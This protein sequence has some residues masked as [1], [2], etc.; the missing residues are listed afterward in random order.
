MPGSA[1]LSPALR[2]IDQLGDRVFLG[3]VL[4]SVVWSALAFVVLAAGV[5]Y[6]GHAILSDQGWLGWLAGAAG[7]LG[8][9]ILSLWLFLPLA[10]VI[11]SLFVERIAAAVER[12]YYPT[13]AQ[14]RP[15]SLVAQAQDGIV[16]GLRVLAMQAIA[17]IATL[18]PPHV[19]GL[20]VGWLI[21]SWAV[22][23][24]LFVPVAML[25]MER[26]QALALYRSQRTAVLFQGALLT[27]AG[28]VP[29]LNL[30]APVLGV[31]AMVH[32]LHR[33]LGNAAQDPH[34]VVPRPAT[35]LGHPGQRSDS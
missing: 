4:H 7:A 3:V 14:G 15:A 8:T 12:V 33:S 35:V 24:G 9:L 21:A 11:A 25:R 34:R 20:A 10:T 17:L 26:P 28:L 16:L 19:T 22:G 1:F 30:L 23:R 5:F 32:L 13:I 2:A 27:A 6:G 18:I 31:A 29:V